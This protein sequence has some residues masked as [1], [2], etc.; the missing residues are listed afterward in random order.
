MFCDYA[1]QFFAL[2]GRVC[3]YTVSFVVFLATELIENRITEIQNSLQSGEEGKETKIGVLRHLISH[4]KLNIEEIY[5][6]ATELLL[7]G[8][9]TV[10]VEK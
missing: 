1:A 9:D 10:R 3:T 5:V 4:T 2:Y 7:G 6:N 8:V